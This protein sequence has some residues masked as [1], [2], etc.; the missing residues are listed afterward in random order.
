ML[1]LKVSCHGD[2]I[3]KTCYFQL[4]LDSNTLKYSFNDDVCVFTIALGDVWA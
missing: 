4:H 3:W 2:H 1:D